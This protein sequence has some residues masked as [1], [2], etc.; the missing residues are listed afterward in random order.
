MTTS[1][2]FID[3]K[4]D[5]PRPDWSAVAGL[6]ARLALLACA[7]ISSGS[8]V[9]QP[10]IGNPT[11]GPAV[12][13]P[14][15]PL[16]NPNLGAV[17][18]QAGRHLSSEPEYERLA[19]DTLQN[20]SRDLA[21]AEKLLNEAVDAC[22]LRLFQSADAA[23]TAVN[24]EIYNSAWLFANPADFTP[25]TS[26]PAVANFWTERDAEWEKM[27]IEAYK[28]SVLLWVRFQAKCLQHETTALPPPGAGNEGSNGPSVEPAKQVAKGDVWV[29]DPRTQQP[30]PGGTITII[31]ADKT[32][33]VMVVPI[34][35]D[36]HAHNVPPTQPGDVIVVVPTCH[37]KAELSGAALNQDPNSGVKVETPAK[38]YTLEF[39]QEGQAPHITRED[40]A[41]NLS[42]RYGVN[43]S[44]DDPRAFQKVESTTTVEGDTYVTVVQIWI[45]AKAQSAVGGGGV[46]EG[47]CAIPLFGVTS[48][49]PP[50]QT[51]ENT[52]GGSKTKE[53]L[54]V[55]DKPDTTPPDEPS[56][57]AGEPTGGPTGGS[58]TGGATPATVVEP[59]FLRRMEG[60]PPPDPFALSK[61]SWGQPYPDQWWL[62]AIDWLKPDGTTVLPEKAEPVTVAVLD[63]GV[64]IAHP[65][66]VGAGWVN[67]ALIGKNR[68]AW[69]KDRG[70][71]GGDVFGWNFVDNNPD[72]RDRTGHGT[73][74]A[75][76]IAARVN[77]DFGIAGINPWAKIMPVKILQ[78]DGEGGS[79]NLA[80]GVYYAVNHGARV[81]NLS[82]GGE[83]L[84]MA[85][86]AALDYAAKKGVVVVVAAGNDG[87]DV[88][89]LSPAGLRN[90]IT[91]GAIGPDLKRPG[92]SNWGANIALVAPALDIL[93]LRAPQTDLL[94]YARKNYKPG[95]AIVQENYYRVTGTSFAAP[96]VSG[97][98]SLLFSVHP[99]YTAA[100]VKRILEQSAREIG[101]IGKDQFTG[102]G[103]IDIDAALKADPAF[104]V[105]AAISSVAAASSNGR[106]VVRVSGTASADKF[107]EG[108]IEIGA[109]EAPSSWKRVSRTFKQPVSGGVLDD[110]E[111][112]VFAGGSVWT[113]R[114]IAVHQGGR[115]RESRF[116]LTLG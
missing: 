21:K 106:T 96:M 105:E 91:V 9:A 45:D 86:Q 33:P 28:E 114:V 67:P 78:I 116:K 3:S 8:V 46:S 64:D 95:T 2:A 74:V 37:Q 42:E 115:Q 39:W 109:G 22:D 44:P 18:G 82:V 71:I 57:Q 77:K 24:E 54:T 79:I 104:Y 80:R 12:G 25:E 15:N 34:D 11:G 66:L 31:P 92:F 36:G 59:D 16:D 13:L 14:G 111:P 19:L 87:K 112:S 90:A 73:V 55:Y 103:L 7:A 30:V 62:R 51:G 49:E 97:A 61:G 100:Q 110:L 81:I 72:I 70:G 52:Q 35:D 93:S 17:A 41:R 68:D 50:A 75:G 102:Y 76:I 63:T 53:P 5:R 6:L 27:K 40:L 69:T 113:L 26:G 38:P 88:A 99:E 85:E 83:Q 29:V 20:I 65:D 4:R 108:Y 84:S 107:K 23:F 94:Q 89:N 32:K 43:V 60:P 1:E 98:A 56:S 101:G 58:P 48:S 10:A 47:G